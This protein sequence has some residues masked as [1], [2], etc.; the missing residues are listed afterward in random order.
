[1]LVLIL[2]G[3]II[4]REEES[5]VLI[6]ELRDKVLRRIRGAEADQREVRNRLTCAWG[7]ICVT[8]HCYMANARVLIVI[9]WLQAIVMLFNEVDSDGSGYI[10]RLELKDMLVA[11]HLHYRW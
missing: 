11:L 7:E 6:E 4:E 2:L 9:V 5:K 1:V 3:E 10:N 8:V